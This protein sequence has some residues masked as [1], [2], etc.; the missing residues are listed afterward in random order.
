MKTISGTYLQNGTSCGGRKTYE[1][2]G[3][4]DKFKAVVVKCLA[5]RFVESSSPVQSL[6]TRFESW[7]RGIER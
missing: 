4:Q 1:K 2:E 5:G 3:Q 6:S 7:S